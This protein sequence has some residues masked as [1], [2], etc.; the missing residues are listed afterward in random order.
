MWF[1]CFVVLLFCCFFVH[2]GG[3][4]IKIF[5][6]FYINSFFI[7]HGNSFFSFFF[8]FSLFFSFQAP[9]GACSYIYTSG[10]TG[11]P[12]AVMVSHDNIIYLSRTVLQHLSESTPFGTRG[13]ERVISYLPLSHVA[14]MMID[15]VSVVVLV[16][17]VLFCCL[18]Y[19]VASVYLEMIFTIV[20]SSWPSLLTLSSDLLSDLLSFCSFSF[21]RFFRSLARLV[22]VKLKMPSQRSVLHVRTI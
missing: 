10:T 21:F 12:K 22:R 8:F 11:R 6:R 16:F 1:C 15:I 9:G 4:T 17:F 7:L 2:Y 19:W 18:I 3:H 20:A 13:Q 14:G 5:P